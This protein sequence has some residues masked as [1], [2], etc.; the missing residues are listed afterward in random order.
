MEFNI[1]LNGQELS[2]VLTGLNTLQG[3]VAAVSDAI[4]NQANEQQ[5]PPQAPETPSV[6]AA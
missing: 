3:S 4:V 5:P 6:P 1:K 2:T